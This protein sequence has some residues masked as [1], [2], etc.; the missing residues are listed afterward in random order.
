MAA[1]SK[2]QLWRRITNR[3]SQVL[4]SQIALDEESLR[5]VVGDIEQAERFAGRRFPEQAQLDDLR[6]QLAQ[7]EEQLTEPARREASG[8]ASPAAEP[9]GRQRTAARAAGPDLG[10]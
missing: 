6:A 1:E 8:A 2:A 4:G 9:P 5:R 7:V 10:R 3:P